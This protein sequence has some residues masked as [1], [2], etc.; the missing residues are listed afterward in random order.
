MTL[1]DGHIGATAVL[2]RGGAEKQVLKLYMGTEDVLTIFE[3]KLAVAAIKAKPL[4]VERYKIP[5]SA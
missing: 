3:A 1:T 2:Y 4:N 5:N